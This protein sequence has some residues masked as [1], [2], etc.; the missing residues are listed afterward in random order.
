VDHVRAEADVAHHLDA[1]RDTRVDR[2]GAD[3]RGDDVVGL[4]ARA[5]LRIH[6]RAAG[7]PALVAVEPGDARD[8]VR[9]LASLGHAAADHLLDLGRV[10]A[11][12]LD[13][14]V[15]HLA[16]QRPGVEPGQLADAG[17]AARD[18]GADGFDDHGFAHWG[19][20]VEWEGGQNRTGPL[21]RAIALAD[22]SRSGSG[23]RSASP[24]CA[25]ADCV[26]SLPA[27]TLRRMPAVS[28][29]AALRAVLARPGLHPMPCCFDAHS[30]RLIEQAASRSRS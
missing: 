23:L 28:S 1:A 21:G 27:C 12:P 30:A 7:A 11:R 2:A 18:R 8:V 15:L 22:R 24:R 13:H 25:S 5:A 9:L 19:S 10:D 14:R 20:P 29:A 4:L 6:R 16:E 26:G 3:E 17:L